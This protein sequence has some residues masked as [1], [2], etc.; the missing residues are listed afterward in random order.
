MLSTEYY[1]IAMR[2][3]DTLRLR[4][5]NDVLAMLCGGYGY[6][7]LHMKWF[8]HPLLDLAVPDSVADQWGDQR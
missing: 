3:S 5:L 7:E 8:G 1:G 2:T 4:L 6:E